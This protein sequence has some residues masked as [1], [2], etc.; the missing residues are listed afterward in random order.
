MLHLASWWTILNTLSLVIVSYC[1]SKRSSKPGETIEHPFEISLWDLSSWP[2]KKRTRARNFWIPI[3]ELAK[4]SCWQTMTT[5]VM[6][7]KLLHRP[8]EE[9]V[10]WC[11]LHQEPAKILAGNLSAVSTTMMVTVVDQCVPFASLR[12]NM[13]TRSAGPTILNVITV[14]TWHALPNGWSCMRNVPVVASRFWNQRRSASRKAWLTIK[15]KR[16]T[17]LILLLP[18]RKEVKR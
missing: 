4:W 1:F 2:K 11:Y 16:K 17:S 12:T 7:S 3:W 15:K 14:F 9:R 8:K 5:I 13:T 18:I 6:T 10:T